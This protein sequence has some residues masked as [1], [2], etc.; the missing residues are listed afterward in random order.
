M[1]TRADWEQRNL[2]LVEE[3]KLSQH[4]AVQASLNG[5][6]RETLGGCPHKHGVMDSI[7]VC[8]ANEMRP[9][10]YETGDGPCELFQQILEEWRIELEICP[11]CGQERPGDERVKGGM[12]CGVCAGYA[13]RDPYQEYLEAGVTPGG[14]E[15]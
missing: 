10:V 1:K 9:C 14:M 7:D 3:A 6:W 5:M 11:E 13:E 8:D 4:D 15:E 12:K 2:D